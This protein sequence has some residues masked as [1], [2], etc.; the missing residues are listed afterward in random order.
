MRADSSKSNVSRTV[1]IAIVA[2]ALLGAASAWGHCQVPCGIYDDA[3]RVARLQEDAT[4]IAKAVT[5]ISSLAAKSDA[6]SVNQATRWVM[7]KETHASQIIEV[8]AEYFL[9]QR[10]KPGEDM[11][12]YHHALA[13]HHAVIL[14]AMKTKQTVDPKA[15]ATLRAAIDKLA[16]YYP[17]HEH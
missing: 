16:E 11:A 9:A 2:I 15:V 5:E 17:P 6:L 7:T 13:D 8:M 12:K 4:T 14:A 3:A 10:V 1:I